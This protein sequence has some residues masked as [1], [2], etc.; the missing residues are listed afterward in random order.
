MIKLTF[1]YRN[2]C[3]S[4]LAF[5]NSLWKKTSYTIAIEIACT[6][7]PVFVRVEM[8]AMGYIFYTYLLPMRWK[9]NQIPLRWPSV[10]HR[11]DWMECQYGLL[12]VL[13]PAKFPFCFRSWI[14]S[15]KAIRPFEAVVPAEVDGSGSAH[16]DILR[17]VD[18]KNENFENS[19]N[20]LISEINPGVENTQA[21]ID[22]KMV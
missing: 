10:G 12:L 22:K 11:W 3:D 6:E 16:R 21:T 14:C 17:P 18:S 2:D 9:I 4:L 20:Q 7:K 1:Q 19:I 13:R 15:K 5:A 8:K